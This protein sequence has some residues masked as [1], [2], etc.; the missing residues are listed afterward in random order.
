M[1]EH[2]TLQLYRSSP[3]AEEAFLKPPAALLLV[4]CDTRYLNII[5][6]NTEYELGKQLLH[7]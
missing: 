1:S 3:S 7:T 6:I 5:L 2:G 4:A